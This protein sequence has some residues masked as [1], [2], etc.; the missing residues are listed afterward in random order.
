MLGGLASTIQNI[1][2]E[3]V[4]SEGVAGA[5]ITYMGTSALWGISPILGAVS[6][7]AN[8]FGYS[9]GAMFKW[10][11]DE[12][13]KLIKD[14]GEFTPDDAKR[15][16][17]QASTKLEAAASLDALHQLNKEGKLSYILQ[18]RGFKDKSG[19]KKHSVKGRSTGIAGALGMFNIFSYFGSG[20]TTFSLLGGF[21]K[22]AL[23][24]VLMG[25]T[26]IEGPKL[27]ANLFGANY[28]KDPSAEAPTQTGGGGGPGSPELVGVPT[29]LTNMLGG[30]K[31]SPSVQQ[32]GQTLQFPKYDHDLEPSGEGENYFI[33]GPNNQ[34][35]IK[36]PGGD[37]RSAMVQW[38]TKIYPKL[39]GH[40]SEIRRS[41][42][43]DRTAYTLAMGYDESR[44]RGWLKVPPSNL[45]TWRDIVDTFAAEAAM[46]IKG[47]EGEK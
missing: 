20:K 39:A 6:M 2:A 32:T 44:M 9:P 30:G 27:V 25:L 42:S 4:R 1:V 46:R 23:W 45:H 40:E 35:W 26:L 31:S 7:A 13:I 17:E 14:K 28:G 8:Y 10:A 47:K 24:A 16:A 19:I 38:A 29:F 15:I 3:R 21:F 18:G 11:Y 33:N 22:W 43:F 41:K 34:W 37:I 12:V 5:L 36:V